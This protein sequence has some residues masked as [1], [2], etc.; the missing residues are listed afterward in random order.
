MEIKLSK[1]RITLDNKELTTL[2]KLV[3]KFTQ[4]MGDVDYV[5][6]SGYMAIFLAG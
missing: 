5:I 6:V 1:N 4:A 3:L 2:D